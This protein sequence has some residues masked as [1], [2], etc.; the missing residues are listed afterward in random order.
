MVMGALRMVNGTA[1]QG[2]AVLTR[3][4]HHSCESV[5]RNGLQNGQWDPLATL[6]DQSNFQLWLDLTVSQ[7]IG[8][9]THNY[10]NIIA[11]KNSMKSIVQP[12]R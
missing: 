3:R 11:I 2:A 1:I 7:F 6:T 12:I 9:L 4:A 8:H 10:P 5:T